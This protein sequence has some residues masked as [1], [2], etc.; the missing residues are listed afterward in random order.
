[1]TKNKKTESKKISKRESIFTVFVFVS[2]LGMLALGT[3]QLNRLQWKNELQATLDKRIEEPVLKEPLPE[4]PVEDLMLRYIRLKGKF[5]H[6]HEIHI[7]GKYDGRKLGYHI[8]TPF[9]TSSGKYYLVNRGW[10]PKEKIDRE[11]RK[12]TL[13]PRRMVVKGIVHPG[14]MVRMKFLLPENIPEK[15][16]WLWVE[17]PQIKDFL[18]TKA[19]IDIEPFVVQQ[20]NDY[21]DLA[22]PKKV[23]MNFRLR[24]DHL[25][26]AITWYA[27]AFGT[28]I[29]FVVYRKKLIQTDKS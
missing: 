6:S 22:L 7:L 9:L 27:L 10:V 12:E 26:Y 15:G 29:M 17:I 21:R 14:E 19:N 8:L 28:L 24:N 1:M 23:K 11:T 25:E 16:Q 3:W 13:I 18:K 4:K 2:V 20:T 5:L